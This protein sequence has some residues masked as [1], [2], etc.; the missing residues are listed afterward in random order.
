MGFLREFSPPLLRDWLEAILVVIITL[1]A[2]GTFR[3]FL[4]RLHTRKGWHFA[5]EL[6]PYLTQLGYVIGLRLFLQVAPLNP[7]ERTW[8]DHG[9]YVLTVL[10]LLVLVR[11]A[12]FIAVNL[13]SE[14]ANHASQA[15][16]QGFI[17]L[18]RNLITLFVLLTGGIMVLKH[19]N[20]DVLSL[21]T[22]LG[23]GSLAVGLAAKETLAN[24]ISGFMLI[25]DRNLR[26]GDRVNFTGTIGDVEQIGLRSTRIR[27]GDG[28]TLVVPN[29]DLVN[30]KIMNLSEPSRSTTC[31]TQ[32]RV[33]YSVS[34][35]EIEQ[36]CLGILGGIGKVDPNRG[37][38]VNLSSL[39]DGYQLI[40]IGCWIKEMDDGGAV[41]TQFH[42]Q[43]LSELYAREIPLIEVGAIQPNLRIQSTP[44]R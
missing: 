5:W 30:T 41:L 44:P 20:Y 38:W 11:K 39:A 24:M 1:S 36:L 32:I 29:F 37:K 10:V 6:G 19:F 35:R 3:T 4:S 18:T 2:L 42:Q 26:P 25:I 13:S 22:A 34:F 28:N 8:L 40:S 43:L 15:L 23:V 27:T 31:T 7:H 21:V 12:A 9:A 16:Q 33:P 14:R 17:P